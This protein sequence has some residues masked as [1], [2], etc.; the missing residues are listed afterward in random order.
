M[1]VK[2]TEC[3][4]CLRG[5]TPEGTLKSSATTPTPAPPHQH[6]QSYCWPCSCL[7]G[8]RAGSTYGG[9]LLRRLSSGKHRARPGFFFLTT[10]PHAEALLAP[11]WH[12]RPCAWKLKRP[13]QQHSEPC[14]RQS[15]GGTPPSTTA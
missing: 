10:S 4:F 11:L 8:L 14:L 2:Q 1:F 12:H 5:R 3:H 13:L 6:D 7:P 15:R 9:F